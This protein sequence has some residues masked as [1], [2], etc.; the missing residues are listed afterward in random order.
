MA[1]IAIPK[2][3]IYME[4]IPLLGNGKTSYVELDEMLKNMKA[5]D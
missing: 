5:D 4:S 1:E 2:K 3:L